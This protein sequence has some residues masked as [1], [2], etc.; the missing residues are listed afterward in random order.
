[1]YKKQIAGGV[2]AAVIAYFF[3]APTLWGWMEPSATARVPTEWYHNTDMPIDIAVS[4]W[5]G[6]YQL[7]E[8]RFCVDSAQTHMQGTTQPCHP[9]TIHRA[10]EREQWNRFTMNRLTYPRTEYIRV[11][12]P[13]GRLAQEGR[14]GPGEVVGEIQL[15]LSHLG[16]V[17]RYSSDGF[18]GERSRKGTHQT[19]FRLLLE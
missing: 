3:I 9:L 17:G 15:Q 18:G 16:S 13:F 8:V 19:P 12:V 10:E 6:N 7:D 2:V 5:H 1:M 11:Y 14:T 4:S